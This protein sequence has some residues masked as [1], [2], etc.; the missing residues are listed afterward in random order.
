MVFGSDTLIAQ[1]TEFCQGNPMIF[2]ADTNAGSGE[3]TT[4]SLFLQEPMSL[5]E[6]YNVDTA[7]SPYTCCNDTESGYGMNA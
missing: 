1:A 2:M 5:L 7:S 6:D 3:V 4:G